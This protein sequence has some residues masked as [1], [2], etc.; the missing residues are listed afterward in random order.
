MSVGDIVVQS[1][2][3]S[4][5]ASKWLAER[6]R[7]VVC[8]HDAPDF[9][10][11]IAVASALVVRTY[12]RV[13]TRLLDAAP[14]LRVV[15]RA[16]VGLDNIDLEACRARGVQVVHTPDA[17][18]QAV[19][20]YVVRLM[21]EAL[22]PLA[23]VTR[24]TPL[25]EWTML[26]DQGEAARQMSGLTLGILGMG[27]IGRRMAEVA[28]A[29][30]MNAMYNDLIEIP[31]EARFGAKPVSAE[32]LFEQADV[33]SIHIDGRKS[34]RRFVGERLIPRMKSDAVLIN[35][36]RGMLIDSVAL[37]VFMRAHP[38]AQAML[39]VHEPEPFD[40]DYPLLGL[41]NVKLYPHLAARTREAME[42]MSWVVRDVVAVLEGRPPQ[43]PAPAT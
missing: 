32:E 40:D 21:G 12:T 18:T 30:R 11:A 34:N 24:S 33:I 23:P 16:G 36:A 4:E 26:R 15:G 43:W 35:A 17:N 25:H 28:R 29:M 37:A 8:P 3:L 7:L 42:N 31:A 5:P 20:E 39:D 1:E 27:R 41:P 13:D 6:C 22:R 19:V 38:R 2:H 9:H 14:R 10:E